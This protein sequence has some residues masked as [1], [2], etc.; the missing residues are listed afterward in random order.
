MTGEGRGQLLTQEDLL[1]L[2]ADEHGGRVPN[3]D[4]GLTAVHVLGHSE[5]RTDSRPRGA[6]RNA[7]AGHRCGSPPP[8]ANDDEESRPAASH[9]TGDH[10]TALISIR[11][12]LQI[13]R[14]KRTSPPPLCYGHHVPSIDRR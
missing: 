9:I 6:A 2:P 1:S 11:Q 12:I 3:S 14:L 8:Y 10:P 7:I 13:I 5:P 4:A